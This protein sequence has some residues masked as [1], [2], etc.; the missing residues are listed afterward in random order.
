LNIKHAIEN[1]QSQ[2]DCEN[3]PNHFF[4]QKAQNYILKELIDLIWVRLSAA[5]FDLVA[6]SDSTEIAKVRPPSS[7][8]LALSEKSDYKN[9]LFSPHQKVEKYFP[10]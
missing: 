4:A 10:L 5:I 3:I 6:E 1:I 7:I 2:P 8:L 9:P